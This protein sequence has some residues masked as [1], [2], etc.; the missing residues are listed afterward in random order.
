MIGGSRTRS[1]AVAALASIFLASAAN[2]ALNGRVVNATT[3]Q[4][5]AGATVILISFEQGMDPIEEVFAG[6]DGSFA[7]TKELVSSG[8]QPLAGLV[9]AE[10][11]GIAYTTTVVK[12][13]TENIEALVYG[14]T[15]KR[16]DPT[17]RILL[18]HPGA[19]EML[20]NESYLFENNLEPP[21]TYSDPDNGSLRFYLPPEA[22][23]IVQVEGQGPARMPLKSSA[24][25]SGEKDIWMVDF[26]V[27]PGNNQIS[28]TYLIPYTGEGELLLRTPYKS[29]MTRVAIPQDVE[30]LSDGVENLG[31]EPQTGAVIYQTPSTPDFKLALKGVGAMRGSSTVQASDPGEA[32]QIRIESTPIADELP[33]LFAFISAILAVGFYNLYSSKK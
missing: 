21:V 19:N 24:L 1:L 25:E 6:Q 13:Q 22:K 20:I 33:W 28:L 14:S 11:G 31:Q 23:G 8:P 12:G 16:L 27:K 7:F 3:G 29:M 32:N 26:P 2:G 30:V 18:L 17:G 15:S 4:P 5:A 9:R 10:F